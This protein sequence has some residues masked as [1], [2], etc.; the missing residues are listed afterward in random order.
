MEKKKPEPLMDWKPIETEPSEETAALVFRPP[1]SEW[2]A[3]IYI[4]RVGGKDPWN[5]GVTHWIPLPEP[6]NA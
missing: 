6:P 2:M 5:P 4:A 3:T 1:E